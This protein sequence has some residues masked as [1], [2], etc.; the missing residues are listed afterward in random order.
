MATGS[1]HSPLSAMLCEKKSVVAANTSALLGVS[2]PMNGV[3]RPPI[4]FSKLGQPGPEVRVAALPERRAGLA[5]DRLETRLAMKPHRETFARLLFGW[6][7][8]SED[9][10]KRDCV[11]VFFNLLDG[12]RP[13]ALA[14]LLEL[15]VLLARARDDVSLDSPTHCPSSKPPGEPIIAGVS[16]LSYALMNQSGLSPASMR[17]VSNSTPDS[18]SNSE[19]RAQYGQKGM[20]GA[21]GRVA[22]DE[23]AR[24][25]PAAVRCARGEDSL[26]GLPRFGLPVPGARLW[27]VRGSRPRMG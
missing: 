12:D 27:T 17:N 8:V 23:L 3:V 22:V 26:E 5:L 13:F 9:H 14:E 2:P 18:M 4:I 16:A 7:D 10:A 19:M 15:L 20:I 6:R 24:G 21:E 11:G 25:V 1:P